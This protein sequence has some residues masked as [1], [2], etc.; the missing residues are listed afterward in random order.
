MKYPGEV[1]TPST[2]VFEGLTE[3]NYPFHDKTVRVTNCGRICIG[4]RK[5]NLSSVFA[6]QIVGITEVSDKIWLVSFMQFDIG[7]FDEDENKVQPA[8]NPFMPKVLPISS[9]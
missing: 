9:V 5:I 6:G 2:R 7:F 4:S 8:I 3:P 1:Y